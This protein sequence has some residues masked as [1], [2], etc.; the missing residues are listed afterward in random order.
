MQ[1]NVI[2]TVCNK[3]RP[4]ISAINT[5]EISEELTSGGIHNG[6]LSMGLSGTGTS[7]VNHTNHNHTQVCISASVNNILPIICEILSLCRLLYDCLCNYFSFSLKL[8]GTCK[9][10]WYKVMGKLY[11]S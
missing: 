2:Y 7:S 4:L 9:Q 1:I 6:Q 10:T 11:I 3:I 8:C 5:P